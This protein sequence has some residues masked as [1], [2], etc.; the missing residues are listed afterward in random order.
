MRVLLTEAEIAG[1]VRRVAA[2]VDDWAG[3]NPVVVVPVMI[4]GMVFCADLVRRMQTPVVLVPLIAKS[5]VGRHQRKSVSVR[6][7][8]D[9]DDLVA[10]RRVLV[11]DGVLDSGKTLRAVCDFL[12]PFEPQEVVTAVLVRK[13]SSDASADFVGQVIPDDFVVGYGMDYRD[14]FRDLPFLGVQE[15]DNGS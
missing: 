7:L 10:G 1:I 5:Y 2:E 6:G 15:D 12:R 11:V 4:G 8:S 3:G 9:S 14:K 13:Q